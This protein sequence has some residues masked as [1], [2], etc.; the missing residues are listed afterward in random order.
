MTFLVEARLRRE[1]QILLEQNTQPAVTEHCGSWCFFPASLAGQH[2]HSSS[3]SPPTGSDSEGSE[4]HH[5]DTT[6]TL[7]MTSMY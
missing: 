2:I 6:P 4:Q 5:Q 3:F 1:L 7:C